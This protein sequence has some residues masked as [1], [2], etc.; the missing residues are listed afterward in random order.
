MFKLILAV[1]LAAILAGCQP[2]EDFDSC[3]DPQFLE[4]C[5][6][7]TGQACYLIPVPASEVDEITA[8]YHTYLLPMEIN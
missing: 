4:D 5:E 8:L 2:A 6:I 1:A 7:A 3:V